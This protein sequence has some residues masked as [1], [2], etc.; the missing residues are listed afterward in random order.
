MAIFLK[1][2]IKFCPRW[3]VV[4]SA[5]SPK[6]MQKQDELARLRLMHITGESAHNA[7]M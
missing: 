3:I 5:V 7:C 4:I 1:N 6:N 2:K